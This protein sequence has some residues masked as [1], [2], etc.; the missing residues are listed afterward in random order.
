[1]PLKEAE[2]VIAEYAPA[3]KEKEGIPTELEELYGKISETSL[4]TH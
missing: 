3:V 1:M 2:Q 4:Q